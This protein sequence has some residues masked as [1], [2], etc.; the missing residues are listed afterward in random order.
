MISHGF[1]L[2]CLHIFTV[3]PSPS[4]TV[5]QHPFFTTMVKLAFACFPVET[6]P[7]PFCPPPSSLSSFA[8][9]FCLPF[10]NFSAETIDKRW[11][12]KGT[13]TIRPL[14]TCVLV[15][16]MEHHVPLPPFRVVEPGPPIRHAC[17]SHG[18]PGL[19]T[20]AQLLILCRGFRTLRISA[21]LQRGGTGG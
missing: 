4:R 19:L 3:L 9:L 13:A 21:W 2:P 20:S 18:A 14:Y 16:V 5:L 6:N 15:L 8:R 12:T 10:S 11:P 1:P 17:E 7:I